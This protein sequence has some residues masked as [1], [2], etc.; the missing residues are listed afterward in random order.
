[1]SILSDITIRDLC[2]LTEPFFDQA[3]YDNLVQE[4]RA[5]PLTTF[6]CD[7]IKSKFRE[8]AHRNR[9]QEELDAFIPMIAPFHP[10]LIRHVEYRETR[11]GELVV[12]D[13]KIISM[14]LTS[15]GYDVC[16]NEDVKLFTNIHSVVI[17]PK[18]FDE[19]KCLVDAKIQTD[20]D[21]SKYVILPPHSYMLGVTVEYFRIPRDIMVVCLGKSTYARCGAIV[22]ATPIEP[23]FEGNVVIEISNST[24]SPMRVYLNE[25]IAQFLFYR[26]D[27]PCKTSYGDRGGKYQGQ[28][29]VTLPK[30]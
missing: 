13:R 23:G 1:M 2:R 29:G 12:D 10:E 19:Q 16:L 25:G 28:R 24:P 27:R 3:M 9:T 18:R 20:E 14:G 6:A 22:N 5:W 7:D 4:Q 21:G 17:D 15:Y 8:R 26:G 30:V 11:G